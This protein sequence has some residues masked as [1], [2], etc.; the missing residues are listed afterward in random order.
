MA[1]RSW[2]YVGIFVLCNILCVVLV[3]RIF[4]Q[5]LGNAVEYMR[6]VVAMQE[7]R[8]EIYERQYAEAALNI[9]DVFDINDAES[10][11]VMINAAVR[12]AQLWVPYY[13]IAE[14]LRD[15][16]ETSYALGLQTAAFSSLPPVA[17]NGSGVGAFTFYDVRITAVYQGSADALLAFAQVLDEGATRLRTLYIN[18]LHDDQAVIRLDFSLFAFFL[19]GGIE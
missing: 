13:R 10:D 8:L 4:L 1:Q 17:I 18:F 9:T 6:T 3:Y 12:D 15:L 7:R 5:P 11:S 14:A 19:R 2:Q 16:E